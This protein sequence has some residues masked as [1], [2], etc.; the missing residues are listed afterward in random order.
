[1]AQIYGAV[2]LLP[3]GHPYLDP[4]NFGRF[5][6]RHV[7]AEAANHLV[8]DRHHLDQVAVFVLLLAGLVLLLS[9]FLLLIVAMMVGYPAYALSVADMLPNPNATTGSLG[10][11]Q[12]I[13]FILMDRVFGVPAI[14]NSCISDLNT[15][16][17]DIDGNAVTSP[18]AFPFPFHVALHRFFAFYSYGI[19]FVGVFVII[20]YIMAIAGE[21]A[22]SGTPFGQRFNRAWAPI[23]LILFFGLLIPFSTASGLN[24]A[25]YIALRVAKL[26][27]NFATNG[28]AYFTTTGSGLGSYTF[29]T[30]QQDLVAQPN[31][32][33]KEIVNL[34]QFMHVVRTCQAAY[35]LEAQK[36]GKEG[37]KAYLVRSPIPASGYGN[38]PTGPPAYA[39]NAWEF[40]GTNY[41][42]AVDFSVMG[43]ITVRF[44]SIEPDEGGNAPGE[45]YQGYLGNVKPLCGDLVF[46]AAAQGEPGSV[47]IQEAYYEIVQDIWQDADLG[48]RALCTVREETPLNHKPDACAGI[49]RIDKDFIEAQSTFYHDQFI[50]GMRDGINEQLDKGVF[51]MNEKILERGWAGAALWYNKIAEM[52]GAVT[53]ASL[54]IPEPRKFPILMER[55]ME[56]NASQNSNV[57]DQGRFDLLMSDLTGRSLL[58]NFK[59]QNDLSI[60]QAM[61]AVYTA[62]QQDGRVVDAGSYSATTGNIFID[63]VNLVLG[64][65]GIF[66]MRKNTDIH[67]LAQLSALG[68]SMMDA[69][70]RN[71]GIAV[72]VTA[73][74]SIFDMFSNFTGEAGKSAVSFLFAM[75]T[76]TIAMAAI[77]YYVLP[78]MPFIYFFFGVSGWLKSIF[79]A[80]AAM[81]LWAL[82]HVRID[83]EGLPGPGA[84]NGYFLLLEIFVR[85]I[86]I[87]IGFIAGITIFAALVNVLNII[88]DLVVANAGGH[89]V[90]LDFDAA[91]GNAPAGTPDMMG[92][93][94][95]AVDR[96]FFTA[97]Y[98]IVCYMIGLSCFKLVDA[99]PNQILRWMGV[100]VHTFQE[101]AGDPAAKLASDVHRG[102]LLVSNQVRDQTQGNLPV[103]LSGS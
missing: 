64:T 36:V 91:A 1:M 41:Q 39:V 55:V 60:F 71:A 75:V 30:Q 53:S 33:I 11:A 92:V 45:D 12:D 57:T 24:G 3:A 29:L 16:C 20:Y 49:G 17:T 43:D 2:R 72:G 96:F 99:I 73:G 34:L 89:D 22:S 27:S 4:R 68:K 54:N 84:S 8:I 38:P 32:Q 35:H 101:S 70:V 50:V 81:P 47:K 44:G 46:K 40:L 67:P 15:G 77:L 13:A 9:Q 61:K 18:T 63:Y 80:M 66:E 86:M 31:V 52:N 42:D 90:Q 51:D 62:W 94:R 25:Q 82:A 56:Q 88:F 69:A 103:I 83:G 26:G 58:I 37:I 95:G 48:S 98:V 65:N 10:P 85:P 59:D 23:R 28:W 14:F 21:T 74:Q 87:V 93:A 78:L 97:V 100:T 5:G 79:E 6:I 19:F 76:V 7:I 102:T